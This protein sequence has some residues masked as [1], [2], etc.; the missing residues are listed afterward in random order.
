MYV[1]YLFNYS[2]VKGHL[3]CLQFVSITNKAADNIYLQFC[4]NIKSSFY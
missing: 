2:L 4:V 1:P 3:S